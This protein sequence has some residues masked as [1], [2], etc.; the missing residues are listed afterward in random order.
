[1]NEFETAKT[2]RKILQYA[3]WE[4][5][6]HA[7]GKVMVTA[8][9][10]LERVKSQLRFPLAL[11]LPGPA[12]FDDDSDQLQ[13][14]RFTVKLVARV[15]GDP[16]GESVILGGPGPGNARHSAGVGILQLQQVLYDSLKLLSATDGVQ[17]QVISASSVAATFDEEL[18]DLAARDYT[19]EAWTGAGQNP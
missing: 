11:I 1:M 16:W 14:A 4:G 9:V 13:V 10:D 7:F 18:G 12:E 2:L 17:V 8:G 15:Q 3:T 19:F 6:G 5:G